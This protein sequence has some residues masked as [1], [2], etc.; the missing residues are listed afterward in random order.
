MNY[1]IC[2]LSVVP[3]RAQDKDQAE[4]ISQLL[5][6]DLVEILKVEDNWSQ[7]RCLYDDYIGWMDTKQITILS[8]DQFKEIRSSQ[9]TITQ[10]HFFK[11]KLEN[12]H[13][14][15]PL[16]LHSTIYKSRF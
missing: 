4:I 6:G 13:S 16:V 15:A 5:L 3:L 7:V 1:G 9:N 2:Q 10:A 8:E 11:I 12:S 14:F